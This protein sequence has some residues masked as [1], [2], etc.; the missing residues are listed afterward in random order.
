VVLR[1][2]MEPV[3]LVETCPTRSTTVP[4]A[5]PLRRTMTSSP[6]KVR[7]LFVRGFRLVMA[8][9]GAYSAGVGGRATTRQVPG[10]KFPERG[11]LTLGVNE[12]LSYCCKT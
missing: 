2:Q 9:S 5:P 10:C 6:L 12:P 3:A 4:D 8:M 11:M 1:L 7:Y